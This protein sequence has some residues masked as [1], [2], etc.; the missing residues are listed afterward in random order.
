M[1]KRLSNHALDLWRGKVRHFFWQNLRKLYLDLL[2]TS[3]SNDVTLLSN[4]KTDAKF[5][6]VDGGFVALVV[7]GGV[8][9]DLGG[10]GVKDGID[11][12][13]IV[14]YVGDVSEIIDTG[15]IRSV[16]VCWFGTS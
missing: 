14:E 1:F 6:S 9:V 8:G 3:F 15:T 5:K 12:G 7:D 4:W 10:E 11:C 16:G 2:T 13:M